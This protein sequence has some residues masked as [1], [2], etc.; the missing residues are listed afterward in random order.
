MRKK[1]HACLNSTA[2]QL[3]S[4]RSSAPKFLCPVIGWNSVV[5]FF[6]FFCVHRRPHIERSAAM[7][8]L[9]QMFRLYV[10]LRSKA[11]TLDDLKGFCVGSLQSLSSL[12]SLSDEE[13]KRLQRS[14]AVSDFPGHGPKRAGIGPDIRN[15][16]NPHLSS[17]KQAELHYNHGRLEISAAS[18]SRPQ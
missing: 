8:R 1:E 5:T 16:L 17:T 9:F 3:P 2:Q 6:V 18:R 7:F 15:A 4:F 12:S 10:R 13:L 14:Q 11:L